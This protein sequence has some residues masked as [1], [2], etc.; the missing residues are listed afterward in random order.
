MQANNGLKKCGNKRCDNANKNENGFI[1][2]C[3]FGKNKGSKDGLE[4]YC[5]E[6]RKLKDKLYFNSHSKKRNLESQRRWR[7][8]NKYRIREQ[9][10]I[11]KEKDVERVLLKKYNISI[12]KYN[13]MLK[14]Q[15]GGCDICK[16]KP[17]KRRHAV[18]HN[19]LTGKIRGLLCVTCNGGLGY[20]KADSHYTGLL[21]KAIEYV[22]KHR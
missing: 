4:C 20:F 6:C 7:E 8:L 21:E 19:H 22:R 3:F 15:N 5:K 12:E 11:N 13:E 9:R 14:I 2:T 18:D 10:K 1:L 17:F 16:E